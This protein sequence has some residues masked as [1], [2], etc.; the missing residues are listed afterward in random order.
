MNQSLPRLIIANGAA[1]LSE[2]LLRIS[3]PRVN[4]I[5]TCFN[6]GQFVRDALDSVA[7]QSYPAFSCVVVD[8]A[9][10]DDSGRIIEQWIAA[11]NDPRFSLVRNATN[12]GQMGSIVAGLAASAGE[13]VALLDADDIWLP[14]FLTRHIE[15]HLNRVQPA[16]VS[17]SDLVQIDEQGRALSGSMMPSPLV[18]EVR[19]GTARLLA[20][21]LAGLDAGNDGLKLPQPIDARYIFADWGTWYWSATSGMVFRRPL[22]ELLVPG[23]TERLRLAADFYLA[24]LSHCF[25]GSFVIRNVLGAYR[26]HG[27]NNFSYLPVLGSPGT[28][29][30]AAHIEN[31]RNAYRTMLEHILEANEKLSIAF[32]PAIVR[33]R[34]RLL[35]RFFLREGIAIDDPRLDAVIGKGRVA[36]DRMRARIGFLRRK[37]S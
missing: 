19:E 8:D 9:S 11:R 15:V 2:P 18:D 3:L 29:P 21:D 30:M 13:F 20:Q 16:G 24:G 32:A 27:K 17:S 23:N 1:A 35:F 34:A 26:R 37:L 7:A 12:L 33:K 28:S 14:E 5:V 10:T 22:V 4:V 25:T 31:S 36:R 6:Y